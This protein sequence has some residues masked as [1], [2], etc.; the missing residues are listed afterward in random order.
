MGYEAHI[1]GVGDRPPASRCAPRAIRAMQAPVGARSSPSAAPRWSR[2]SAR[3][4]RPR[5]RQRRRHRQPRADGA[6]SAAITEVTAGSGLYAPAPV[7]PL[8]RVHAAARRAVR[9]AG[10][11]PAG[12]GA[13][14][15][16]SAAATSR[17]APPAATGCPC[18][19]CPPGLRLDAARG[20][21]RGADAAAR[22]RGRPRCASATACSSATPRRAS[23]ASASTAAPR[24]GRPGRRRGADLPR[25]GPDLPVGVSSR[26]GIRDPGRCG[27]PIHGH[28][29]TATTTPRTP[30]RASRPVTKLPDT[31]TACLFDLDGG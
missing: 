24:R 31:I 11:A 16:C 26:G 21:R 8:P 10:R 29:A 15:P 17:R 25:R 28:P 2:R 18:P 5:V 6:P 22:R 4:R 27:R 13:S 1:A 19:T 9:A 12:A 30:P 20:R 7:R 14:S 23:C 3:W